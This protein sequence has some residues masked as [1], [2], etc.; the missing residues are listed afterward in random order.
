MVSDGIYANK[1][2]NDICYCLNTA[3]GIN[4]VLS[5]ISLFLQE[6]C[7]LILIALNAMLLFVWNYQN[8]MEKRFV[9]LI[10][11]CS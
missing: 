3:D 9:L 4:Y 8:F 7:Y 2:T 10:L 1:N 11:D 5:Q 6:Q